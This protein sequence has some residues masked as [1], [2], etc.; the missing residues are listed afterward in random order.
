MKLLREIR[1]LLSIG[2]IWGVLWAVLAIMIGTIIGAIDPGQIDVGEEPVILAPVIGVV[3]FIC[4]TVFGALLI[5]LERGMASLDL[6]RARVAIWGALVS[7]ALPLVAGKG[8]PE[9]VVTIPLGAVSAIASVAI[10]G[11][12]PAL[13]VTR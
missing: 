6:P 2:F 8:I 11:K 3:G 7:A 10:I 9:M 12:R 1:R 13:P 5:A 4:G